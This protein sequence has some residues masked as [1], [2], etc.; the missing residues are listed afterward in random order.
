MIPLY[1]IA[2]DPLEHQKIGESF[3]LVRNRNKVMIAPEF[4]IILKNQGI[5]WDSYIILD[6]LA[7]AKLTN[8]TDIETLQ[9]GLRSFEQNNVDIRTRPLDATTHQWQWICRTTLQRNWL[10]APQKEMLKDLLQTH[11]ILGPDITLERIV[12]QKIIHPDQTLGCD[13][14]TLDID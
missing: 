2:L 6:Y 13:F 8:S 1:P 4:T 12:W 14:P 7:L 9:S 3:S 5:S 10:D 11:I